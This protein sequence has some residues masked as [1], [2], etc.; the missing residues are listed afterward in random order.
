MIG[1]EDDIYDAIY[2][3][4]SIDQRERIL[5]II[6]QSHDVTEKDMEAAQLQICEAAFKYKREYYSENHIFQWFDAYELG[7]IECLTIPDGTLRL[8]IKHLKDINGEGITR[9]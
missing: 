4:M 3:R 1:A 6:S 8:K 9:F 5:A 7:D 2:W